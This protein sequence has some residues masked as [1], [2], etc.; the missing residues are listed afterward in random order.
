MDR[1][2]SLNILYVETLDAMGILRSKLRTS[3]FPFLG[4]ILGMR[5]YPMGKIELPVTFGDCSNSRTETLIFEVVNFEA[6]YHAILGC[7]G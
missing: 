1:G 7:P 5:A 3:I 2:S 4:V 6:S